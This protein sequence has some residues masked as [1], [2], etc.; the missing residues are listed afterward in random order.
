MIGEVENILPSDNEDFTRARIRFSLIS[1][2][3][4]MFIS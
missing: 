2:L 3:C 4:A 1:A